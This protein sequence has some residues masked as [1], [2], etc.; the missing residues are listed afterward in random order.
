MQSRLPMA[1]LDWDRV[2]RIQPL[3][4]ADARVDP[5]GAVLWEREVGPARATDARPPRDAFEASSGVRRLRAGIVVRRARERREDEAGARDE[6]A[7]PR[8]AQP[9]SVVPFDATVWVECPRCQARVPRRRLLF[10]ARAG[11]TREVR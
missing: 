6:A 7:V 5:D 1:R 3:D 2:R 4:G 10:H 11:C 8:P 9:R